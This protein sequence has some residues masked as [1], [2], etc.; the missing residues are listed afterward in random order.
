MAQAGGA[1]RKPT[2]E[3]RLT[4]HTATQFNNHGYHPSIRDLYG[5]WPSISDWRISIWH[6][7]TDETTAPNGS[8]GWPSCLVW[9]R[10]SVRGGPWPSAPNMQHPTETLYSS[11]WQISC[12]DIFV[13]LK[14]SLLRH[15]YLFTYELLWHRYLGCVIRLFY[16]VFF[17]TLFV[18]GWLRGRPLARKYLT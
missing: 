6:G 18:G 13:V 10:S 7:V 2:A 3:P 8:C 14:Y 11:R 9:W 17:Q 4:Y 1:P 16:F 15:T 5:N 12:Y